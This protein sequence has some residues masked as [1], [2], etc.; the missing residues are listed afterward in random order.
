MREIVNR[1]TIGTSIGV[2]CSAAGLTG[3]PCIQPIPSQRQFGLPERGQR[4]VGSALVVYS[5]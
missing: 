3:L 2:G 1:E 5:L 4:K